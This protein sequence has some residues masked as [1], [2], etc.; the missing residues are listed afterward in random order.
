MNLLSNGIK[1]TTKGQV[2]IN[3]SLAPSHFI[4]KED[5]KSIKILF[6]V[7]DTGKGINP[8]SFPRLFKRFSQIDSSI[9][10]NFGGTG[11]GLV[12]CKNLVHL[13]GGEIGVE[14]KVDMGSK[15]WFTILFK[16]SE[17]KPNEI[18]EDIWYFNKNIIQKIHV[19][20]ISSNSWTREI[21]K[22]YIE[23]LK[24]HC[25]LFNSVDDNVINFIQDNKFAEISLLLIV[26][27]RNYLS[28]I[29][30]LNNLIKNKNNLNQKNN[31]N[32]IVIIDKGICQNNIS[33][34]SNY[35][36]IIHSPIKQSQI[37]QT[38]N[39][40]LSSTKKFNNELINKNIENKL[41][42][43]Q[44]NND[45]NNQINKGKILIVEDNIVNQKVIGMMLKTLGYNY[46]I[47]CNGKEA[48]EIVT[49]NFYDLIFMDC[50]MPIMDGYE[51]TVQ[52][53]KMEKKNNSYY[54]YIFISIY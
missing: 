48:V 15:F 18:Y 3:C 23:S 42:N 1:F 26:D 25:T 30:E 52:I 5:K 53:R 47:A 35:I 7:I 24:F 11:L 17:I 36:T 38:I 14:S 45:N 19:V 2:L 49:K 8:E 6:E 37:F 9:T 51:A 33:I 20:I 10:R 28:G 44:N 32:I 16:P 13:M 39:Q 40:I 54:L 41:I 46:D 12:I 4:T 50:Q 34:S 31:N 21:L 43:N 29:E 27:H 22:K